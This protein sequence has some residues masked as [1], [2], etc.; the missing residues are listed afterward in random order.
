MIYSECIFTF[1]MV[2]VAGWVSQEADSEME[3]SVQEVY[4]RMLL[5]STSGERSSWGEGKV[6]RHC[7]LQVI[8]DSLLQNYP[9][10]SWGDRDFML[11]NWLIVGCSPPCEG[12]GKAIPKGLR[13]ERCLLLALPA[14]GVKSSLFHGRNLGGTSQCPPLC[15][16]IN[17]SLNFNAVKFIFWLIFLN[18]I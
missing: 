17:R 10:F 3:T 1:W 11:S 15:L 12:T 5:G 2:S 14:A 7:S 4:L 13:A 9:K 8:A 16:L 6:E 18:P